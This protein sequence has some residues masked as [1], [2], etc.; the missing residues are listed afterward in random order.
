MTAEDVPADERVLVLAPTAKDAAVTH[1]FLRAAGVPA[2][3]CKTFDGL[4]DELRRGAAAILI[5]EEVESPTRTAV[6]T[7]YL[8][9]QPDWS[10]LPVLVLTREG[11]DSVASRSQTCCRPTAC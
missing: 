2:E 4:V 11:A 1:A 5:P 9:W 3:A 10:D 8:A 7:E 6:L